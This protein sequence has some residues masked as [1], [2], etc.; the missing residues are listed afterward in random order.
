MVTLPYHMDHWKRTLVFYV[1]YVQYEAIIH[2][3]NGDERVSFEDI[4]Y[5]T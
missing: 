1:H 3:G 5:M 4:N 2:R